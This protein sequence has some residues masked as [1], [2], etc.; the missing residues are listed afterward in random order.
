MI[1]LKF[2]TGEIEKSKCIFGSS[3][4]IKSLAKFIL[5][6]KQSLNFFQNSGVIRSI[7][8]K[9]YEVPSFKCSLSEF[10][11]FCCL[12]WINVNY[13]FKNKLLP[14]CIKTQRL[15]ISHNIFKTVHDL[16]C[17]CCGFKTQE[18]FY[19]Y[20]EAAE[21]FEEFQDKIN[22]RYIEILKIHC[23]FTT[24]LFNSFF[25]D[26]EELGDEDYSD[27]TGDLR[28]Q[29]FNNVARKYRDDVKKT[30]SFEDVSSL[31]YKMIDELVLLT[32]P[33]LSRETIYDNIL[34]N[35]QQSENYWM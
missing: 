23:T 34:R 31:I 13:D 32:A 25:P 1:V 29:Y 9:V 3:R 22:E 8:F 30:K 17:T 2:V 16:K 18:F 35:S 10:L 24:V 7:M 5:C 4:N 15:M 12:N 27:E 11:R 6:S 33:P 19:T 26:D 20:K 21:A 28:F 14:G